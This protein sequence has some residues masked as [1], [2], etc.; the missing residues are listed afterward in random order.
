ME[1]KD[2]LDRVLAKNNICSPK[3]YD[4]LLA[5]YKAAVE[6]GRFN[7]Q[8]IHKNLVIP[9]AT[10]ELQGDLV[11]RYTLIHKIG[12]G[13]T[14]EKM[15]LMY[16]EIDGKARWEE[17]RKKHREKNTFVGKQMRYGWSKEQFDEFNKSRAVT[18]DNLKIKY[19]IEEGTKRWDDYRNTQK[20]N[21][22]S[23]EWF[24]SKYGPVVG[25]VVYVEVCKSKGHTL[26]NYQK[27][28]G[29]DAGLKKFIEYNT[30]SR[31]V[32]NSKASVKFFTALDS[33]LKSVKG[34]NSLS[35]YFAPKNKEF[36]KYDVDLSRVYFYD[37][38]VPSIG[39]IV[40]Y[41]GDL[42]HANPKT[43]KPTDIPRFRGNTLTA[44]EIWEYDDRKA[45]VAKTHGYDI[46]YVWDSDTSANFDSEL[47]RV[48]DEIKS[49]I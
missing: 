2:M 19:G 16:G 12:K 26:D 38:A 47:K 11:E 13:V 44:A 27:R 21:G 36:C 4:Q 35:A 37:Y 18:L 42:Y 45:E 9:W 48:Y 20:I 41:N 31:V 43:Y 22:S 14:E 30:N 5:L 33:K 25:P 10:M 28:Y 49:R 17:Y 32:H 8:T 29:V 39:I 6:D 3:N 24:V 7:I 46:L 23:I 15:I 40:E 1:A 34:Y